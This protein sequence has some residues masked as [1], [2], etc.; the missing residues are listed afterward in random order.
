MVQEVNGVFKAEKLKGREKEAVRRKAT[1]EAISKDVQ[2]RE[3]PLR[4]DR[5]CP[6]LG[7]PTPPAVPA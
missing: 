3:R 4:S 5:T 2:S 1:L 7:Q 6:G